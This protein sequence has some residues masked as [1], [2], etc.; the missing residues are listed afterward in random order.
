V[1]FRSL[2]EAKTKKLFI[3]SFFD[4]NLIEKRIIIKRKLSKN[5]KLVPLDNPKKMYEVNIRNK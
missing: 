2:I 3:L 1:L 4:F 5:S